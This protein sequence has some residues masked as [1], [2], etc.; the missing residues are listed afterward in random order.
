MNSSTTETSGAL[1]KATSGEGLSL[2]RFRHHCTNRKC[3]HRGKLWSR[4]LS[5]AE[6]I[7]FGGA[8]YCC[9]DCAEVAFEQ[10]IERQFQLARQERSRPHRIPLGLLLIS[11]GVI[12][13]THL[14]E[15]LRLQ[16][17]RPKFRLGSLLSEMGV[18]SQ[19]TLIAALAVQWGCPVFPLENNRAYLDCA[20]LLP[21]A[22]LQSACVLPVH[23]SAARR[24]LHLAFTRRVDHT[25]LYAIEGMLGYR[26]APCVASEHAVAAALQRVR[27]FCLSQE[28]VFDSVSQSHEM[29]RMAADYARK[30]EAVRARATGA[31]DSIWFRFDNS[32]GTH[33]LLFQYQVQGYSEE[34]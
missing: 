2:S 14:Q 13:S 16:Q 4:W 30:L 8:G 18:L 3:L 15:A 22:L 10:E 7:E 21:Y 1:R 34:T 25:L 12:T 5:R 26:V 6:G 19:E 28:T 32:R 11:R 9:S 33:H 20:G 23:H 27:R 29:A 24:V 31:A 17:E